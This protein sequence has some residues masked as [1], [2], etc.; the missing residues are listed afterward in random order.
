MNAL[1]RIITEN[2]KKS[3]PSL[4]AKSKKLKILK[5]K[6]FF[7][8]CYTSLLLK[9]TNKTMENIEKKEE[10]NLIKNTLK[11]KVK[12]DGYKLIAG[13]I[14]IAGILIAGAI[15]LREQAPAQNADGLNLKD[16]KLTSVT[17]NDHLQGNSKAK[18]VIVE[19]S[20]FE[21]PF[22][23]VFDAT[24]KKVMETKGKE[25]ALIYR[26]FPLDCIDSPT[27]D[28]C[29]TLHKLARPEAEATECAW[30]Q[31]GN[32]LFWK[33]ADEIFSRT[34]SNDGLDPA[35]LPKIATTLNLDLQKFS[36]CTS[37]RKYQVKVSTDVKSGIEAGV[38]GTPKAFILK[39]GKIVDIIDGAL[40]YTAVIQKIEK[41]LQ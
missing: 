23:K 18:I 5:I 1:F 29:R 32:D 17:A 38:R 4:N 35:E 13:T 6:K 3:Y 22:C 28:Q 12:M 40:P 8:I 10:N 20:D 39:K 25:I 2:D 26:H 9:I 37:I 15:L 7:Y 11:N 27:P 21:C 41:A 31:G 14:L 30:E 24:M 16:I 33:Y 34:K 19:Y 36:D